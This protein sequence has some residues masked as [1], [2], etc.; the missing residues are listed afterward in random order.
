MFNK[1]LANLPF[2]PSLVTQISFY[3]KRLKQESSVRRLGFGF[4]ALALAI[5]IFAVVA[6]PQASVQASSNDIIS[7]GFNGSDPKANLI[8]IVFTDNSDGVHTGY[9]ALY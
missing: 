6:P 4:V 9:Q 2:N 8:N 3:G 7:G 5:Q 1:L